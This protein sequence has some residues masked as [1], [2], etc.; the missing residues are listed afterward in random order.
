MSILT[1]SVSEHIAL[2]PFMLHDIRGNIVAKLRSKVGTYISTYGYIKDVM[3]IDISPLGEVSRMSEDV[4]FTTTYTIHHVIPRVDDVYECT[5][6][7]IIPRGIFCSFEKIFILLPIQP[8][9]DYDDTSGASMR[10]GE[11]VFHEGDTIRA[12]ITT[13]KFEN[14]YKC[15]G[16]IANELIN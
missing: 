16:K 4:L 9:W 10:V 1:S 13:V 11:L 5:I 2:K 7:T 15:I 8:D 3:D 6:H 14:M 12:Q